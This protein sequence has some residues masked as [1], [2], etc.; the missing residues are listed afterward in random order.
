[1]AHIVILGAGFGGISAAHHLRKN[2]P[3]LQKRA[4][5]LGSRHTITLIDQR[6]HH[7]LPFYLYEVA[8]AYITEE[9]EK[10]FL[11]IANTV[12]IP[13]RD[14]F[15]EEDFMRCVEDSIVRISLKDR[16]VFLKKGGFVSYDYLIVGLG[17]EVNYFDIPGARDYGLGLKDVGDALNIRNKIEELYYQKQGGSVEIVIA[18]G[19]FSGCELAGELSFFL[20]KLGR[21]L[22]LGTEPHIRIMEAGHRILPGASHE[23]ARLAEERLKKI[24]VTIK[25]GRMITKVTK[26]HIVHV[27]GEDTAKRK[28]TEK[29]PYD[30]LI[31]TTG[32]TPNSL[33]KT[34]QGAELHHGCLIVNNTLQVGAYREVFAIG[35]NTH[36]Y[37]EKARMKIPATAYYAIEQ[38]RAAAKNILY[39]L[40]GFSPEPYFPRKPIF[41]ISLGSKYAVVDL[42]KIRVTG[43]T[44]WVMRHVV[45][46]RYFCEIMPVSRAF[47]FWIRS[48]LLFIKND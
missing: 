33:L 43:F 22:R 13:L 45:S 18:G 5:A 40:E 9:K 19:G 23:A 38:G 2:L 27:D 28:K 46:L 7:L 35:D 37:D 16:K 17:A 14:I 42:G 25:Y 21:I 6:N 20:K 8:T 41:A 39:L 31:W 26:Q 1:M 4:G 24:G 15:E 47:L 36:C 29:L 32:I 3:R 12:R 11:H 30:I 34:I 10:D 48:M 44:G